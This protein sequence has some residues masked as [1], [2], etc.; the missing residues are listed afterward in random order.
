MT[1]P[2]ASFPRAVPRRRRVPPPGPA[3]TLG[4]LGLRPGD[5]VVVY[6]HSPK[7]KVYG[8]LLAIE[9]PG[10]TARC[11]DLAAFDNWMRQEARGDDQ[12]LGPATIFYPMSR[13]ERIERDETIGPVIS[14]YER[15]F[16]ET[17]RTIHAAMGFAP[18]EK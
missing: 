10:V 16:R 14:L 9:A 4:E 17:G 6:L 18:A 3:S 15:F 12:H 1:R 13:V 8:I 5:P 11:I 2:R 7:E